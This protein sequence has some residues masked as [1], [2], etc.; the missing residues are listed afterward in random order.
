MVVFGIQTIGGS[1][2]LVM[3]VDSVHLVTLYCNP[4][5]HSCNPTMRKTHFTKCM[6]VYYI[7]LINNP[8]QL[9]V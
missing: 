2:S 1:L 9:N 8:M 7:L 5:K 6:Q 3:C 4:T